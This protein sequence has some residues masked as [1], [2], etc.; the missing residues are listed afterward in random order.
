MGRNRHTQK[1]YTRN[2]RKHGEKTNPNITIY[3]EGGES[4]VNS[5]D[6][7]FNKIRKEN[8]PTPIKT[9]LYKSKEHTEHKPT[10]P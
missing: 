4:H 1:R 7:I 8:L 2:V 10:R 5:K 3:S 6:Q 9:H